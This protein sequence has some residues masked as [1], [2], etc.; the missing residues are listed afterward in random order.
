MTPEENIP[1]DETKPEPAV[2]S[3]AAQEAHE[4]ALAS[5]MTE[6][7][8]GVRYSFN[9]APITAEQKKALGIQDEN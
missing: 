4:K 5:M 6:E 9:G 7:K 1:K 2:T 8:D 3:E